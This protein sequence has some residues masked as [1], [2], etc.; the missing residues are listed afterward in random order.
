MLGPVSSTSSIDDRAVRDP[1]GTY[2]VPREHIRVYGKHP[3]RR[4]LG[5][6]G[7]ATGGPRCL[8]MRG[9]LRGFRPLDSTG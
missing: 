5:R 7:P 2:V 4:Y 3:R 6:V 9:A 8:S 1:E